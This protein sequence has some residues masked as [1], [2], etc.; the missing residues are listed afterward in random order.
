MDQKTAR[1]AR[2]LWLH[3]GVFWSSAIAVGLLAVLHAWLIDFGY[4]LFRAGF[5][6]HPWLALIVT[7]AVG[8][9]CVALTR[10]FLRG[11]QGSGIAQVVATL[12]GDTAALGTRL[13]TVRLLAGKVLV[14]FVAMLGGF[15]IKRE[16]PTV[17]VDAALI[18]S[19]C[20]ARRRI[21][22]RHARTACVATHDLYDQGCGISILT[23][24]T[25]RSSCRSR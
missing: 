11:A 7:P 21:R 19:A 13:L 12:H 3:Y 2:R 25:S 16:G 15:T 9:L 17:Q 6:C 5:D 1:H 10:R 22:T 18:Y 24:S 20:T 14:S 4:S 23:S 8:A